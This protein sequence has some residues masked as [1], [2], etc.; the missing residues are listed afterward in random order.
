M[1]NCDVLGWVKRVGMGKEVRWMGLG[2]GK[3]RVYGDTE[4][5]VNRT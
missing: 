4:V 1:V 3:I 2:K 5:E